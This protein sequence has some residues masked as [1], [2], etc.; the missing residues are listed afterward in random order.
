MGLEHLEFHTRH[1]AHGIL[2]WRLVPR[3]RQVMS[4]ELP[5]ATQAWSESLDTESL[6]ELSWAGGG[7]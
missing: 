4:K 6:L 1:V 2:P 5:G 3:Q 7:T